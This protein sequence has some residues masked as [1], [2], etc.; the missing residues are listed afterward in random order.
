[1]DG[2]VSDRDRILAALRNAGTQG[3]HSHDL[4]KL[5]YSGNP[6]QRVA[7]LRDDGHRITGE[8]ER[9]NKRH[10]I[11]WWLIEEARVGNG[12][13]PDSSSPVKS[14]ASAPGSSSVSGSAPGHPASVAPPDREPAR[15][16][17]A[18]RLFMPPPLDPLRDPEAA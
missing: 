14:A 17:L 2:G 18:E 12:A 13:A 3:M 10:G 8:L 1:V 15:Q 9:R 16:P 4:R 11:R 5:G 6:S 7:E